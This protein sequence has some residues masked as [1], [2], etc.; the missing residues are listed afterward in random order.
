M[1]RHRL[2]KDERGSAVV[3]STL[4]IVVLM[5]LVLGTVQVAL[6]LYG[7][8]V[9]MTA[10]HEGARA[11]VEIGR[12]PADGAIKAR[13]MIERTTGSIVRDLDIVVGQESWG[14]R[15]VV[16][17]RVSGKLGTF[18]PVP[19]PVRIPTRASATREEADL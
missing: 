19:V 10:A 13:Q 16:S 14:G 11:A 2:L 1:R 5:F 9:L 6:V 18:G 7:R 17:V 12:D 4:S 15:D 3:E 8:N